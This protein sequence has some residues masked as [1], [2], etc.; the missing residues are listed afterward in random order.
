LLRLVAFSFSLFLV[1]ALFL[2]NPPHDTLIK[3]VQRKPA[4]WQTVMVAFEDGKRLLEEADFAE[5]VWV[6]GFDAVFF[7][8]VLDQGKTEKKKGGDLRVQFVGGSF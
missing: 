4:S 8:L 6:F 5:L 1:L 7:S 2:N 3:Q